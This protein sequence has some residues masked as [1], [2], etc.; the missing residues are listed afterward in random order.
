MATG[1]FDMV[2]PKLTIFALANG[3]D[4]VKERDDERLLTWYREGR[5]RAIVIGAGDENGL[6]LSAAAWATNKPET[7][8]TRLMSEGVDPE[9]LSKSLSG[10]LEDVLDAA[11]DL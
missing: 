4:L 5:E 2:D 11:N 7:R 6:T 8:Q 1:P 10:T 3:M 9:A